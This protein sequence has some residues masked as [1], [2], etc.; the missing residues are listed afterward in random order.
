MALGFLFVEK[1][2]ES[3]GAFRLFVWTVVMATIVA[4]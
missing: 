2:E 1:D 3:H 4:L